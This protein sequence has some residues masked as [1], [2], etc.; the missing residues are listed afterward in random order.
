MKNVIKE[1]LNSSKFIFTKKTEII[2]NF[3]ILVVEKMI[4]SKKELEELSK[5]LPEEMKIGDFNEI[6]EELISSDVLVEFP[7]KGGSFLIVHPDF[8]EKLFEK[9]FQIFAD[10]FGSNPFQNGRGPFEIIIVE[11]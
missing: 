6:V 9:M 3:L 10:R 1:V 2:A 11:F 7:E 8:S 5:D 4:V